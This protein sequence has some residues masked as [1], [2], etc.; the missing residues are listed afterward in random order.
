[1]TALEVHRQLLSFAF[2]V[3]FGFEKSMQQTTN[4]LRSL[5]IIRHWHCPRL[6]MDLELTRDSLIEIHEDEQ[7]CTCPF[8]SSAFYLS[9]LMIFFRLD[10]L[11]DH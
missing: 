1:M 4:C 11:H 10:Q 3:Q 6:D 8:Y 9:V 5:L 2:S 7:H